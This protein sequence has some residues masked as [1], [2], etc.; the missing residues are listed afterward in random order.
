MTSPTKLRTYPAYAY[1]A[2]GRRFQIDEMTDGTFVVTVTDYKT[3]ALIESITV[4]G[5]D[6]VAAFTQVHGFENAARATGA[7]R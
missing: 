1:T 7:K 4:P 5:P 6:S 3:G 2:Y